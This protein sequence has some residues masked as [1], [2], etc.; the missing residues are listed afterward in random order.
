MQCTSPM[1]GYRPGPGA[2]NRRLVHN[3]RDGFAD[4]P[5]VHRCGQCL[6]CRIVARGHMATRA[7]L[8]AREHPDGT[9]WFITL[10]YSDEN[11]PPSGSLSK[12]ECQ[13]LIRRLRDAGYN[14][15]YKIVG[16]YGE[17][18][19]R[20]H[21][22]LL[23]YG[24]PLTDLVLFDTN[25]AGEKLFT[26]E[27]LARFWPFGHHLIGN[28]TAE[29]AGYCTEY[30]NKR[31]TG[32]AAAEHYRRVDPRT[33]QAWDVLPEFSLQS[34]KPGLGLPWWRKYSGEC[35]NNGFVIIKG[36]KRPIPPYF[37]RHVSDSDAASLKADRR[38]AAVQLAEAERLAHEAANPD[39]LNSQ[40]RRL[41]RHLLSKERQQKRV[42]DL[43][44]V[45]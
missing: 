6:N 28:L 3:P 26:S 29:S 7:V 37:L 11:A 20:P 34:L 18:F 14:V 2:E 8:E 31:V 32:E 12:L 9:C 25:S 44:G 1:S 33:G 40:S 43:G 42:R 41:T 27:T 4:L 16:E 38:A 15:R 22:H 17:T 35:L 30:V 23:V 5:I 39:P 36:D 13:S 45:A 24:L 10:T 21:Y 19:G